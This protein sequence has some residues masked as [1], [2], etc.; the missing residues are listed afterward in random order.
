MSKFSALFLLS[1]VTPYSPSRDN[2]ARTCKALIAFNVLARISF[3]FCNRLGMPPNRGVL[4]LKYSK[5]PLRCFLES[6]YRT[7][8]SNRDGPHRPG[9]TNPENSSATTSKRGQARVGIRLWAWRLVGVS[10]LL[11]PLTSC[12][13]YITS[14][15]NLPVQ[16]ALGLETSVSQTASG[17][18]IIAASY[19][20]T[21]AT[22]ECSD[23][24]FLE[25]S[26]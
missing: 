21:D 10:F 24:F 15:A 5:P 13:L 3:S 18:P 14:P 20:S 2:F 16:L 19:S 7:R 26:S 4:G 1:A 6:G 23:P 11:L 8:E 22:C 12:F 17:K 9:A 25:T